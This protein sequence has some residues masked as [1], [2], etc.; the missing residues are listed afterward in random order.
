M[1][2]HISY[3]KK[4]KNNDSIEDKIICQLYNS[5]FTIFMNN[6]E[7]IEPFMII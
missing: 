7:E 5:F 3:L 1:F 4:C 2:F 6:I